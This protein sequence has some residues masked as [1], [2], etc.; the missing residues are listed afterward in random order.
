MTQTDIDGVLPL[1]KPRGISSA[2]AAAQIKKM[3]GAR[4]AGHGGALDPLADGLLIVLLGEAT[5]FAQFVLGAEKTYTATV[6]FG[7]QTETDDSEGNIVFAAP[8]PADLRERA[9][10]LLPQFTG[11]IMQTAPR[12]SAL[13]EKGE[14]AYKRARKGLSVSEKTRKL[15]VREI[16]VT[17][18]DADDGN[19]GDSA[20]VPLQ[21]MEFRICAQSGFYVR[22][23][24]RDLG[25]AIGCGAHL[26]SLTRTAS[27]SFTMEKAAHLHS[28]AN[29]EARIK[30]LLPAEAALMRFP[31]RELAPA[32]IAR[33][34]CGQTA[35]CNGDGE[36][37]NENNNSGDNDSG[38]EE[39]MMR[40]YSPAGKFAG[41]ARGANGHLRPL[42][43]LRWTRTETE[44]GSG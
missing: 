36:N 33:M 18:A 10:G 28:L 2:K 11:D 29:D 3:F 31:R 13:K 37:K 40:V 12:F 9:R 7:A 24:A 4:K 21:K 22:A 5:A 35:H 14:P 34:G 42:R 44:N 32:Q 1:V 19:G 23:F 15:Y 39:K 20:A 27:G 26:S 6:A 38:N 25:K 8:P 17:N 43:F 30:H 41:I 16:T